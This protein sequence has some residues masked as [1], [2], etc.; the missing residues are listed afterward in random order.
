ML[1]QP[2][3]V[4][5]VPVVS[6]DYQAIGRDAA[7]HLLEQGRSSLL[8]LGGGKTSWYSRTL[9][10]GIREAVEGSSADLTVVD[11]QFQHKPAHVAVARLLT[12]G[13]RPAGIV[14]ANTPMAMGAIRA[15]GEAGL[16]IPADVGVV[17]CRN[18]PLA[19]YV[20]PSLTAVAVDRHGETAVDALLRRM[21]GETVATATILPHSLI[22]RESTG[23]VGMR[24]G[25]PARIGDSPP[26]GA[27]QGRS[28]RAGR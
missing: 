13:Y 16:G 3:G 11:G 8:F 21:A 23:F 18:E 2:V 28:R 20:T 7:A 15:L 22:M 14:A 1:A 26:P 9:E 6:F 17:V 25:V 27:S 5:G 19:E 12:Q 24:E 10:W 4:P